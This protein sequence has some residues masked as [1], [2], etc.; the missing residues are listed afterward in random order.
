MGNAAN[1]LDVGRTWKGGVC[2]VEIGE[3]VLSDISRY[4][5]NH[6]SLGVEDQ[7]GSFE[8]ILRR[9]DT[10]RHIDRHSQILEI[11]TGTGWFPILCS[12]NGLTCKGM[13]ISADLVELARR[14]GDQR[15]VTLDLE[16]GDIAQANLSASTYDLVVACSVFEH[17]KH[18]QRGVRNVYQSLKPGGVMY[19]YSTNR[20]SLVSGEYAFPFYGWLPDRWRFSLRTSHQGQDI[21]NWGIDFHQFTYPQLRQFFTEAGFSLVLDWVQILRRTIYDHRAAQQHLI[22]ALSAVPPLKYLA[23]TFAPGTFFLCVK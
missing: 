8:T 6:E 5:A 9:V 22:K 15:G 3:G 19:F 18:W 20:F 12:L 16:L 21:M 4:I 13:D 7:K 11:G 1:R 10:L 23:L 17:V 14:L 2:V